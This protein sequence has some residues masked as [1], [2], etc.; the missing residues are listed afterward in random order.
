[1]HLFWFH[2]SPFERAVRG[3][4]IE[5]TIKILPIFDVLFFFIHQIPV[6]H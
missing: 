2:D 5:K 1:M 4:P 3:P 6:L